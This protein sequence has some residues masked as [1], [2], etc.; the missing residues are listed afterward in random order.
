MGKVRDQKNKASTEVAR[1][2]FSHRRALAQ[3]RKDAKEFAESMRTGVDPAEAVQDVLD[4]VHGAWQYA[5]QQV[6]HLDESDYWVD[7]LGMK[8][9]NHW[10]REQERLANMIVTIA[11]RAAGMGLAERMVRLEE[12]QAE[13]F[14]RAVEAALVAAGLNFDQRQA[15]HGTIAENLDDVEALGTDVILTDGKKKAKAA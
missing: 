8:V 12:M 3:V 7:S 14:G 5:T 15:I 6:M 1:R 9:P 11:G 13:I 4:E 2:Q 10:I